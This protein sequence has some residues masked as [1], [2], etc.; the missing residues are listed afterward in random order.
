V[1]IVAHTVPPHTLPN[2]PQPLVPSPPP[3]WT[4]QFCTIF[5]KIQHKPTP[6]LNSEPKPTLTRLS[7]PKPGRR[8]PPNPQKL[9]SQPLQLSVPSK[10][11]RSFARAVENVKFAIMSAT[12]PHHGS[13]LRNR[14]PILEKLKEIL[15]EPAAECKPLVLEIASGT[16]CH[17]EVFAPALPRMTF[18]PT[19]YIPEQ[20]AGDDVDIGR[21]G[22]FGGP[23]SS[24]P[25][26]STINKHGSAA[27]PN[28]VEAAPLDAGTPFTN[29][30]ATV[31]E[32]KGTF[33]MVCVSN[34]THISPFKVTKGICAGAGHALGVGG[35]LVVYG[36]FKIDGTFTTE[37]NEAFDKSLK[38]RN[39]EW[40]YRDVAEVTAEAEAAS[41][42]LVKR[43]V[44]PANNFLLHFVK[45]E[46][47]T[48]AL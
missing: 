13:A 9:C 33:E 24:D 14:G 27:H 1:L 16:G 47:T 39:P 41:L 20:N 35:S 5:F 32:Q 25:I 46:G 15:G 36:P 11:L 6:P 7:T 2:K 18:Y 28:V 21:I 37:S 45:V 43:H 23:P 30:P 19:E 29:W 48:A 22:T 4:N 10:L 12:S 8:L 17:V 42:T 34:V 40:G 44:M 3:G 31:Q 38:G 26:L